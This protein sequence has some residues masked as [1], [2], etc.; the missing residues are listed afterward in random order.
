MGWLWAKKQIPQVVEK[1]KS[2]DEPKE[3]LERTE[4]R[5]TQVGLAGYSG[6]GHPGF[7]ARQSR[8]S[9]KRVDGLFLRAKQSGVNA[10]LAMARVF[11]VPCVSHFAPVYPEIRLLAEGMVH[12]LRPAGV[13]SRHQHVW[14]PSKRA[15]P[16]AFTAICSHKC[17]TQSSTRLPICLLISAKLGENDGVNAPVIY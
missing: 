8:G 4:L 1:F 16:T 14:F 11:S 3:A 7:G 15:W 17:S 13:A 10:C 6:A 5:P 12:T 2:G 9:A